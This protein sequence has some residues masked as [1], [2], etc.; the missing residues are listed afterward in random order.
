MQLFSDFEGSTSP[1]QQNLPTPGGFDVFYALAAVLGF[2]LFH[3]VDN[4]SNKDLTYY[5]QLSAASP[6][7]LH[8]YAAGVVSTILPIEAMVTV[9]LPINYLVTYPELFHEDHHNTAS[10]GICE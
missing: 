5:E 7:T 8:G 1:P 6:S 2:A 10:R 4:H 3:G 9:F